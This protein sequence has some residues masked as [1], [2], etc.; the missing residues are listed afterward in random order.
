VTFKKFGVCRQSAAATALWMIWFYELVLKIQSGVALRLPP[1]SKKLPLFICAALFGFAL[2][3]SPLNALAQKKDSSTLFPVRQ[4]GKWGYIDRKGTLVIQP[5]FDEAW[6]FSEGLAYVKTGT[7]RGIIDSRGKTVI[8]LQQVDFAGRF[9][10]GLA[11]AQTGGASPRWGFIDRNGRLVINP[12]FDAVEDFQEGMAVV[13]VNR[14]YGFI[15]KKGRAVV[16]PQ[17]DKAFDFHE[18]LALVVTNNRF[19]FINKTGKTHKGKPG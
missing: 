10:E 8:D 5:Q 19:G 9:S 3:L 6:D 11:P 2:A 4:N 7:R 12:Q 18:G 1:R 13:M 15:D 14:K 16:P 17:F